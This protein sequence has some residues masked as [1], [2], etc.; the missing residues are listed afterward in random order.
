MH[1]MN[2]NS[3]RAEAHQVRRWSPQTRSAQVR[4]ATISHQAGAAPACRDFDDAI[5]MQIGPELCGS[6]P[7]S[8]GRLSPCETT[9][10][11]G[12]R[13]WT[14]LSKW[15]TVGALASDTELGRSATE[16][17]SRGGR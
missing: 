7:A 4:P 15:M 14:G 9:A 1:R 6:D 11:F 3:Q 2:L 12:G 10:R 16:P 8:G 13:R 5:Q 17:P